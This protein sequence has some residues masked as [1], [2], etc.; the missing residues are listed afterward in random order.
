MEAKKEMNQRTTNN[1]EL[2]PGKEEET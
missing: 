1:N 2:A